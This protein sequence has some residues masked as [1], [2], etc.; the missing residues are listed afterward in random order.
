M[1][2]PPSH[3]DESPQSSGYQAP[4][5]GYGPGGQGAPPP[6]GYASSDDRTWS[7]LSHGLGPVGV[8]VGAGVLGWVGPLVCYLAKGKESPTVRAHALQAL[9]FNIT[10][11]VID[12]VAAIIASCLGAFFFGPQ[13]L[14]AVTL[15]PIIFGIIGTVRANDGQLYRYPLSFPLVK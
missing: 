9:N 8:V 5:P 7:L 3:P 6:P 15:V 12:L 1:T 13:I 2:E 10:W 11:A 4:P 14:W